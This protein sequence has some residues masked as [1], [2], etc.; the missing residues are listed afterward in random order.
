MW[1]WQG[2][3]P[4]ADL[5]HRMGVVVPLTREKALLPRLYVCTRAHTRSRVRPSGPS[6]QDQAGRCPVVARRR[7]SGRQAGRE[8]G[9]RPRIRVPRTGVHRQG[10]QLAQ[11][12]RMAGVA[13]ASR[14]PVRLRDCSRTPQRLTWIDIR[15][16]GRAAAP[17]EEASPPTSMGVSS[18]SSTGPLQKPLA[19]GLAVPL[20]SAAW[21][22]GGA[23]TAGQVQGGRAAG[24]E[25]GLSP[26]AFVFQST[27]TCHAAVVAGVGCAGHS[28]LWCGA[29]KCE[30]GSGQ[31]SRGGR[32]A[33]GGGGGAVW[34]H[35][36]KGRPVRATT[37]GTRGREGQ[38]A[39]VCVCVQSWLKAQ[40]QEFLQRTL[41]TVASPTLTSEALRF[42]G[43]TAV[44]AGAAS[45]HE[46]APTAA[47]AVPAQA[48]RT[49]QRVYQP[50]AAYHVVWCKW[51]LPLHVH[52]C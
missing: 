41:G 17:E 32:G 47:G 22:G 39:V 38:A 8:G 11:A 2:A 26:Q 23:G 51:Q 46:H 44:P 3:A 4:S 16:S 52:A 1:R 21:G 37:Q 27:C 9:G 20:C 15:P 29:G 34:Q 30:E 28:V 36:G 6:E 10:G 19:S 42:L 18:S 14:Q 45:L 49:H 31:I 12:G 25:L 5:R 50:V 13:V 48:P 43:A 7:G 24:D 35:V 33:G 40:R